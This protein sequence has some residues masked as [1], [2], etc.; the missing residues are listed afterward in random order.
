[1]E[2]EEEE[3]NEE[4]SG[5]A[6]EVSSTDKEI[7]N[8]TEQ[9]ENM[10]I[11]MIIENEPHVSSEETAVECF[12]REEPMAIE[13]ALPSSDEVKNGLC[14]ELPDSD[15]KI[16]I[17]TNE[18]KYPEEDILIRNDACS[19]D[20]MVPKVSSMVICDEKVMVD[21]NVTDDL[22]KCNSDIRKRKRGHPRK[23]SIQENLERNK[24]KIK[25][26]CHMS[27]F[28]KVALDNELESLAQSF[29]DNEGFD[30]KQHKLAGRHK[31]KLQSTKFRKDTAV[32]DLKKG[33]MKKQRGK[34]RKVSSPVANKLGFGKSEI[35][36]EEQCGGSGDFGQET[37]E[38]EKEGVDM[39]VENMPLG[40]KADS[41][42][43]V[44]KMCNETKS[45][46]TTLVTVNG[47][48]NTN[49]LILPV[50]S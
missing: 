11:E 4:L 28:N 14:D 46:S 50:E 35:H 24:R 1:M 37:T 18:E 16:S 10:G 36:F 15:I 39:T 43:D 38:E 33:V 31:K 2:T 12:V 48:E 27:A 26:P 32:N 9:C 30:R 20:D 42:I 49:V 44:Q 17:D 21:Q 41:S 22:V 6:P 45:S 13:S 29:S 5:P 3:T 25:S 23:P 40:V 8:K 7:K 19:N 34:A 47:I